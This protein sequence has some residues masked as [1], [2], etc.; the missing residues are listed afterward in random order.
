MM[1]ADD[2][3]VEGLEIASLVED[4][5]SNSVSLLETAISHFQKAGDGMLE[6]RAKAHLRAIE[7][8]QASQRGSMSNTETSDG[9]QDIKNAILAYLEA[10]MVQDAK[11]LCETHCSL[12]QLTGLGK[13]I[14]RLSSPFSPSC[15]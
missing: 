6:R 11:R 10:G 3:R 7:F 5:E 4:S 2:W 14:G 15:S 8:E 12:P 1:T 13:R 9:I